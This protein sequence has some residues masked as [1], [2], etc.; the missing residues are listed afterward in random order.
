MIVLGQSAP[1]TGLEGW[2]LF[3][4]AIG[5][6]VTALGLA[7][8]VGRHRREDA[9]RRNAL[10]P[11]LEVSIEERAALASPPGT[12]DVVG[13]ADSGDLGVLEVSL[14]NP[15]DKERPV[16]PVA[17]DFVAPSGGRLSL[18]GMDGDVDLGEE[19]A[20]GDRV[21]F[22]LPL[23]YV[24]WVLSELGNSGGRVAT[25]L[26]V[27]DALGNVYGRETTVDV[28]RWSPPPLPPVPGLAPGPYHPGEEVVFWF[29]LEHEEEVEE[30]LAIYEHQQG[31]GP[32]DVYLFGQVEVEAFHGGRALSWVDLSGRVP[33][34][35]APGT[36]ERIHFMATYPARGAVELD[37]R[38]APKRIE[39]AAPGSGV[40]EFGEETGR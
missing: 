11:T 6:V 3:V 38:L 1:G 24:A 12:G 13:P 15:P 23:D 30:V 29:P 5:V 26:E 28:D 40:R 31:K 36:Y 18:S 34:D 8:A 19:I 14:T 10:N 20:P 35:A 22:W 17:M 4:G 9:R 33:R 16:R 7:Y 21:C 2:G 25:R 37:E 39:V 27:R 32:S